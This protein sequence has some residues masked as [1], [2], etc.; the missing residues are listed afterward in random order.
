MSDSLLTPWTIQPARLLCPWYSSGKNSA[1][2]CH[3]LQGIFLTQGSNLSLLHCK[4]TLTEAGRLPA[5]GH[6]AGKQY[7]G[8]PDAILYRLSY[9]G[10]TII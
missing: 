8:V 3:S 5:R 6:P 9:Q 7:R 2:G 10:S 1:V 4:D